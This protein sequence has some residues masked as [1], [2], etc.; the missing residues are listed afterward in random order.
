MATSQVVV[1]EKYENI[2]NQTLNQWAQYLKEP[3]KSQFIKNTILYRTERGLNEMTAFSLYKALDRAFS[4]EDSPEGS[5]YW[6]NI[7]QNLQ[8]YVSPKYAPRIDLKII[9]DVRELTDKTV[10]K[11]KEKDKIDDNISVIYRAITNLPIT[12]SEFKK[13]YIEDSINSTNNTYIWRRYA[14]SEEDAL[15]YYSDSNVK[16][17]YML[18]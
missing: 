6:L 14:S 12:L 13:R 10:Q 18:T 15:L 17:I 11:I 3:F 5:A 7:Q 16:F 4:W 2:T 8:D 1:L 9:Q